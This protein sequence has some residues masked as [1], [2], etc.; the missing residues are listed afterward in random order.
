MQNSWKTTLAFEVIAAGGG[1]HHT[2][3]HGLNRKQ[4][5]DMRPYRLVRYG[6]AI[7]AGLLMVGCLAAL[8][9]RSVTLEWEPKGPEPEGYRL[10]R[11]FDGEAYDYSAPI[12][13]GPDI[14][15]VDKCPAGRT[16]FWVV[17]AYQ[18]KHESRDSNEVTSTGPK[19]RS[20]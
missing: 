13:Q 18:G 3:F 1:T 12:Y 10:F 7:L 14:R 9:A 4:E 11:R 19:V 16:C 6:V 20:P 15:F 2:P 5:A 8:L 17:R